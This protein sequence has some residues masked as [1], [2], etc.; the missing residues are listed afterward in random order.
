MT[1]TIIKRSPGKVEREMVWG[2]RKWAVGVEKRN[3]RAGAQRG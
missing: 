1:N 3:P 2:I